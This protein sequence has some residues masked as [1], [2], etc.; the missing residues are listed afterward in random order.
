MI[1]RRLL[2]GLRLLTWSLRRLLHGCLEQERDDCLLGPVAVLRLLQAQGIYAFI[3]RASAQ[4]AEFQ[5]L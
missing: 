2:V 3:R 5:S 1:G 4:L